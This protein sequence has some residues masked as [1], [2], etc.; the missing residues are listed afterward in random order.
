VDILRA[1]EGED[2][3]PRSLHL[4]VVLVGVPL[5]VLVLEMTELILLVVVVEVLAQQQKV[6]AATVVPEL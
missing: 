6:E 4:L 3:H 5:E 2:N 1:V